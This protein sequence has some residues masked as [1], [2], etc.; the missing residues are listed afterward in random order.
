[1]ST[2]IY[3]HSRCR[4]HD[5][6]LGH[7]ESAARLDAVDQALADSQLAGL[8]HLEAPLASHEQ[9]ARAHTPAYVESILAAIP[10]HGLRALDADTIASPGS[11][12][13][14]R[15]AAG[16]VIAAVDSVLGDRASNAFCAVRPPGHHAERERAMGFCLFNSIAAGACH[17]LEVHGL[18]RV[19]IVDFDVHHGNGTQDIFWSDPRVCYG[20]SHQMP[21]YP[22]TGSSSETGCGNIVNT[23]LD[24]GSG[25]PAFRQAWTD[26]ILPAVKNFRPQL[27]LVSAGFDAHRLDPLAGLGLE[28]GDFAWL[29]QKLCELAAE[30]CGGRLVSMLEGGYHRQALS[31]CTLAHVGALQSASVS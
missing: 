2:L 16:A 13:A 28:T 3:S 31:E 9:L 27:L 18:E 4:D 14:A 23:P 12:D 21:L 19:A 11:A 17:A 24:P 29:S 30:I 26:V 1:M 25:P 8:T 7:P 20:S 10:D 6:G 15:H 5:T 22:G